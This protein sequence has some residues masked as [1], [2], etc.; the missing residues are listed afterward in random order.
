MNQMSIFV[1]KHYLLDICGDPIS[2]P[3]KQTKILITVDLGQA[4]KVAHRKS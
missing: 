2:R 4:P 1:N 3:N